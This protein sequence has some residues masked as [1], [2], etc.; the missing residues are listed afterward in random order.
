MELK[1]VEADLIAAG[2][3]NWKVTDDFPLGPVGLSVP[4][5]NPRYVP[6]TEYELAAE[7]SHEDSG[8]GPLLWRYA[9]AKLADSAARTPD[10]EKGEA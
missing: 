1:K 4:L 2:A 6:D 10:T 7:L 3:L 8:Y 9:L 5:N